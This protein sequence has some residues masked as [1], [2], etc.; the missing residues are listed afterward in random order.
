MNE[1]DDDL[2]ISGAF[3]DFQHAAE[4]SVRPAGSSA[5]RGLAV[6]RRRARI[7][8]L[9]VVGALI[10]A[11]P[12]ATYAALDQ[13]NQGP[14][15]V[16]GESASPTP[17]ESSVPLPTVSATPSAP[18]VTAEAFKTAYFAA[19]DDFSP[20]K[21][22]SFTPDGQIKLHAT[23]GPDDYGHVAA[24]ITVSPDGTKLAWFDNNKDLYVANINGSNKRKLLSG[25]EANGRYS[26]TWTPDGQR[27]ITNK[28][29]V[30]VSTGA[31]SPSTVQGPY[32][33]WSPG[34]QFY[35]YSIHRGDTPYVVVVRPDGTGVSESRSRCE[36]CNS[37]DRSVLAVS[38]DGR[39]VAT[40]GW[41]TTG[42]REQTW[43]NV[44]DTQT[45][46]DLT[47]TLQGPNSGRFLAD[48]TILLAQGKQLKVMSIDGTVLKT[49]TL[50]S[51][52]TSGAEMLRVS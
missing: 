23:I 8:M 21:I 16:P 36:N 6:Q 30:V 10:I 33:T 37:D 48:G 24:S 45:G 52:L 13:D 35:A 20:V 17:V 7:T 18:P 14:P 12:V 19:G 11:A 29:T 34:G 40:G 25:L 41:P 15:V 4:P 46:K 42:E 27:L 43:R 3:R 28:G 38:P 1:H 26:P 49:Y 51:E 2:L 39:Y 9:S 47:L 44:I 50:P 31:I 5:I 32:G 22:Y